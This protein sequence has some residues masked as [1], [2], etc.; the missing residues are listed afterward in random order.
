MFGW[1]RRWRYRILRSYYEKVLAENRAWKAQWR[2][3]HG[4]E[5]FPITPEERRS[6]KEKRDRLREELSPERFKEVWPDD[7]D[8][9]FGLEDEPPTMQGKR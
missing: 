5:P 1:L 8:R 9:L 6:L 4:D 2:A 7:D 3:E